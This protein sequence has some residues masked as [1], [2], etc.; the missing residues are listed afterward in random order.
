M[1]KEKVSK[2]IK[3]V[4]WNDTP[5]IKYLP[6]DDKNTK[7]HIQK[8]TP[9]S[10]FFPEDVEIIN[11]ILERRKKKWEEKSDYF[12]SA[13]Q[14]TEMCYTFSYRSHAI[15]YCSSPLSGAFPGQSFESNIE[16]WGGY[17]C[18]GIVHERLGSSPIPEIELFSEDNDTA[19]LKEKYDAP[20]VEKRGEY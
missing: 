2:T 13:C 14:Q 20:V 17:N 6:E 1:T 8:I 15:I 18:N 10:R 19:L 12:F 3:K 7:K 5:T 16:I 9:L 11:K 4:R